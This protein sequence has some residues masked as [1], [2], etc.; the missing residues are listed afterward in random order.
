MSLGFFYDDIWGG[1]GKIE[2]EVVAGQFP[3][4][5]VA[6]EAAG[7]GQA[8]V[9]GLEEQ[10]VPYAYQTGYQ[11]Y[12]DIPSEMLLGMRGLHGMGQLG[13]AIPGISRDTTMKV[14]GFSVLGVA[15]A[16]AFYMYMSRRK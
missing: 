3:E 4:G 7:Y 8:L 6:E 10:A 14:I 11:A 13:Q 1:V 16:I 9:P 12:E 2:R 15:A 5:F